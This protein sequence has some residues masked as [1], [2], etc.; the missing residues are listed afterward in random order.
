MKDRKNFLSGITTDTKDI[1]QLIDL[2]SKQKDKD[3]G[4]ATDS[5]NHVGHPVFKKSATD[6]IDIKLKRRSSSS[7]I[8]KIEGAID[9]SAS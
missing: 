3:K 4:I 6:I 2:I 9:I 8:R 5:I 1:D 7:I